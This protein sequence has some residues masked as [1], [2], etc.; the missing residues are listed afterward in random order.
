MKKVRGSKI[1][2]TD[3]ELRRQSLAPD[4]IGTDLR[5]LERGTCRGR[6]FLDVDVGI[7]VMRHNLKAM[8]DEMTTEKGT[9]EPWTVMSSGHQN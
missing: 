6:Y 4:W 1:L 8:W 3:R 5:G 2:G 7:V 9:D